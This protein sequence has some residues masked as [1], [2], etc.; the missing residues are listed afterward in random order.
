ME[1]QKITVSPDRLPPFNRDFFGSGNILTRIGS[2]A[3]GGKATGLIFIKEIIDA[4]FGEC[5]FK[6]IHVTIP[7]MAVLTTDIFESFMNRNGLYDLPFH[8]M[9]DD[10][11]AH[12]FQQADFPAEMIGDLRG[13]ISVVHRPLAVRSS[14]MLEDALSEP[15]AGV[16]STKMIPNNQHDIDTRFRKLVEAVKFVY[17]STFF[18]SAKDYISATGRPASDEK[19]AV[20]IQEVVGERFNDYFYPHIS[21]VARSYNFYTV[22]RLQPEEGVVNLALGLGK[23]IVDGGLSWT[24]SPRHPRVNPPVGSPEEL[25]NLSQTT[26]WAVNMGKPPEHDPLKET[27]YLLSC[28]LSDAERDGTLDFIASTFRPQDGG[29]EEGIRSTGPRILTFAPILQG[30]TIPLN[31]LLTRLLKL[32]EESIGCEVEMEF[33]LTL[34]PQ[35]GIPARFGFL[36]VRPMVV[37]HDC[38]DVSPEEMTAENLLASSD[39]VLGNGIVEHIEDVVYVVPETFDAQHTRVIASE[40]DQINRQMMADKRHYLLIGFGRWGSSDP[41][42]GIPVEWGQVSGARVIIEA[43]RPG[44]DIELSQGAH[45]FHN[46]SSFRV[47]YFPIHHSGD[48]SIDWDWLEQQREI[49]RT[50]FVRQVRLAKPLK[51]RVDGRTGKGVILT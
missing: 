49:M 9:P 16:Y 12:A 10:R 28:S 3:I 24:Y 4:E 15:F 30:S 45:F 44:M 20:I 26:F 29:L 37:S 8:D 23:T 40:L 31:E 13:L 36:Q 47:C 19:M 51:V 43:T 48:H 27:E 41:W 39:R 6:G 17:A 11:I 38:V 25:L 32:S 34:D 18:K 1:R 7:R 50:E 42:L 46:L 2:G 35:K 5:D 21:G 33:A 22:G 14:S